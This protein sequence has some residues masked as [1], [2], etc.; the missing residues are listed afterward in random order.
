MR[1][2]LQ[3]TV[4]VSAGSLVT[5]GT[6]L[7][8]AKASALLIGPAGV[9]QMALM[10]NLISL[11]ALVF[12]LGTGP[13][14]VRLCASALA[15]GDHAR[16]ALLRRA[17]WWLI[18]G[19][20]CLAVL[21]MVALRAPISAWMLGVPDREGVVILLALAVPITVA[22][23]L[24]M[25]ILNAHHRLAALTRITIAQSIVGALVSVACIWA[26]REEG[27]VPALIGIAIVYALASRIGLMVERVG[28]AA[29]STRDETFG[30]VRELARFGGPYTLSTLVGTGVQLVL[31]ILVLHALG[32]ESVGWYGAAA[33]ISLGYPAFLLNAMA[34]D[35]F[36]RLSAARARPLELM[37]LI[38]QQH[39]LV[40]M[41]STP[42][43]LGLLAAAPFIV[44]LIY[45][46]QFAPAV[47]VLQWLLVADLLKFGSWTMGYAILA[48]SGSTTYLMTEVVAGLTLLGAG[49]LGMQLGGLSGLGLGY[50]AAYAAYYG[51]VWLVLR[52]E[53][54][55]R[56]SISSTWMLP[57]ALGCALVVQLLPLFGGAE[58]KVLVA[59]AFAM[60]AGAMSLQSVWSILVGGLRHAR[61]R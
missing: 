52:E 23:T 7:V 5:I 35:Y 31:P 60:L 33:A 6:G 1:Q 29:P 14:I 53:I 25:S 15:D 12:G 40:M 49:W 18:G 56:L 30:G 47:E 55:L 22:S 59:V 36:P 28:G 39:H 13:G 51:I 46:S 37:T 16:V 26:W 21:V 41:L 17:A 3:N 2:L 32:K 61:A 11:A 48:R 24:Q 38:N 20:G 44:P 42:L 54:G 43:I 4:I 10:Q 57:A 34:Q 50:V 9:G 27:L 8:T 45:S 19:T 58:L